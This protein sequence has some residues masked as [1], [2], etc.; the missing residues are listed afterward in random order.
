MPMLPDPGKYIEVDPGVELY[1]EDVGAG[2]PLIFIPGWT[3]TSEVF[4]HQVSHFSKTHRVIVVDP[5]SQGRSTITPHGNDYTTHAADLAKL[6]KALDLQQVILC[7]WSFGALAVWGY[8]RQEGIANVKAVAN[9][10]LSFKPLSVNGDDWT[11]GPLDE[12]AGAATTFFMSSK[13]QRDFVEYYATNVM[14]QRPLEPAELFWIVEQSLKTPY[15]IASN[16][17]ANGMFS[18]YQVEAQLVD[19]SVPALHIVAEHWSETAVAFM[20]KHCPKTKTAVLGGHMMFWEHADAFNKVL[21]E[22]ISGV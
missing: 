17:F 2:T 19:A 14:I 22:F 11:E 12:I 15:Y 10:D 18:N 13:G 1:Y 16:L 20:N 7:G 8:I 3:F 9:V 21:G 4:E 5:R 6:I